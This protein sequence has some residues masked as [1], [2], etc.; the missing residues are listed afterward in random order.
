M[1]ELGVERECAHRQHQESDVG[2]EQE[3]QDPLPQRHRHLVYRVAHQMQLLL[4]AVEALHHPAFELAEQVV[5]VARDHVD[6]V[7]LQRL[8]VGP[9]FRLAHRALR[10]LQVTATR[11]HERPHESGGVVLHLRLHHVVHLL[12]AQDY[13][14]G[15]AGVGAGRHGR[16]VC[17]LQN[18]EAGRGRVGSAGRHVD[19]HRHRRSKNLLDDFAGRVDQSARRA[20]FN[21]HRVRIGLA[22]ALDGAIYILRADG[23][24]G[25]VYFDLDHAVGK[26]VAGCQQRQDEAAERDSSASHVA[27]FRRDLPQ[28]LW[29][30]LLGGDIVF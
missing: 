28:L 14:M 30:F 23:L 11:S 16:N 20:Q 27:S 18:K 15:R 2:V 24:D 10:Q 5:L 29:T 26:G 8:L 19:N 7:L 21:Q 4:L 1:I 25:V 9:R 22:G 13:R 17:R 6:Q 3:I 12:A